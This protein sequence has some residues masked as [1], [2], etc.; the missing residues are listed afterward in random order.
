MIRIVQVP[1]DLTPANAARIAAAMRI[2]KL[3]LPNTPESEILGIRKKLHDPVSIGFRSILL[4]AENHRNQVRAFAHALH[5]VDVKFLYLD[6]LASDPEHPGR[7]LGAMLYQSL[8]EIARK[9]DCFGIF[10]EAFPDNEE[11]CPDP[12]IRQQNVRR[13]AFYRR[14]GAL[15]IIGTLYDTP[16]TP[17]DL[18]SPYL[19]FDGLDRGLDL[20]RADAQKVVRAILERKY[21]GQC[22]P[23][24]TERVIAS[25][26]DDPVRLRVPKTDVKSPALQIERA[27]LSIV[28]SD[29][30]DIH[31]VRERGYFE[32]PVRV[33][34]ILAGLR[35]TIGIERIP[36]TEWG[37]EPVLAVHDA[38]LVSYME[39][40]CTSLTTDLPVYPYVFP[41]RNVARPPKQ[42]AVRAGYY[43]IDTFTPLTRNV[44]PAARD[45]VNS[46]LTAA[47]LVVD[48]QRISYA[49]VRPPGH[50]AERHVFGGF[51]YL[52]NAAIA[53][54]YLSTFGK[55]VVLDID[56]HHGN[57]IQ[58]IF[59]QRRDVLTISIHGEPSVAYPYFSG[60]SE[61]CGE[62]DGEGYNLNLPLPEKIDAAGYLDALK[63]A[64]ARISDFAPDF[65][66]VA[67]GLD[68]ASGDPTG[69][70][71]L[72]GRDFFDI[73]R[74]IGQIQKPTL[75]V[76]EGGYRTR[77]IGH[78][79]AAFFE[80]LNSLVTK[81][82]HHRKATAV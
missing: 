66:V 81:K 54:N 8:R 25:F 40:V 53:A 13:L 7:G 59:W 50:H 69:S 11:A 4:V 52:N 10:L 78:N 28:V 79:A 37:L 64:L 38:G 82:I 58:D 57:G 12:K 22:P 51:C 48:G 21:R 16:I 27:R 39:Q 2:L 14:Y 55:V 15:P 26:A 30:H 76:Q 17:G 61:E 43:C 77:S 31:H 60:F 5:D 9:L 56:Y 24:Y 20:K 68:T 62:G 44:W 6:Y 34:S 73:G 45:A 46:A 47:K 1:D 72:I 71:P 32:A 67:L 19:L 49:L 42:L 63:S 36:A 23:D 65:L 35:T 3:Q 74:M 33:E 29:K 80:G 75:I 70:W 18:M 41:V